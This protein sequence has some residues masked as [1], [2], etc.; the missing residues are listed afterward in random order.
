MHTTFF[1]S[2]V[3]EKTVKDGKSSSSV[4]IAAEI[5]AIAGVAAGYKDAIPPL[6]QGPNDINRIDS[7]RAWHFHHANIRGILQSA[8]ACQVSSGIRTP[9]TQKR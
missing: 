7:T 9:A 1:Y 4:V 8:H 2:Y 3:F 5:M 6:L